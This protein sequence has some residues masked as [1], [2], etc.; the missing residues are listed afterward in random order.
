MCFKSLVWSE[1]THKNDNWKHKETYFWNVNFAM[2]TVYSEITLSKKSYHVETSQS[3]FFTD[4]LTG[5]YMMQ[6][7]ST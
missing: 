1:C 5:Y 3:I 7:S 2:I 6:G 4:Q